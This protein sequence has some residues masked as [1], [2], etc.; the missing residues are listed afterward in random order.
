M[1]I[2]FTS[3]T[4]HYHKINEQTIATKLDNTNIDLSVLENLYL[5]KLILRNMD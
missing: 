1:T 3:N 5:N 2:F 4:K